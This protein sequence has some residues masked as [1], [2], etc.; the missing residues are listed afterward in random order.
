MGKKRIKIISGEEQ[1]T[2]SAKSAAAKGKKGKVKPVV[3]SG[4]GGEGRLADMGAVAL[5]EMEKIKEVEKKAK[6]EKAAIALAKKPK[7]KVKVKARSKSYKKARKLINLEKL[8]SVSEAVKL[9]KKTSLA[10][11]NG[12]VEVH[13]NAKETG[14]LGSVKFPYSTGKT[15][16]IQ[17]ANDKIINQ[18][19]KGKIDFDILLATPNQ[20]PKLTKYAKV[21]GPQGLMPNP[22]NKTITE[23]PKKRKKELE[24]QKTEVKTE[25]KFPL[26]HLCIGKVNQP[27]KELTANL[28]ALIE[29]LPPTKVKKI[30]LCSTMGPGIKVSLDSITAQAA[31]F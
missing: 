23:D 16:K 9:L 19:S 28:K 20:V 21:L 13:I 8:Y 6:E 22:K 30:T 25:K 3:K 2:V 26:V 14:V 27:E 18:I 12:T 7:K 11:F 1:A 10:K 29:V 17:I 5:S 4:K 15:K 31:R 24:T